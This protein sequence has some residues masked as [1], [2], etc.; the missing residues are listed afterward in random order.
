MINL[1]KSPKIGTYKVVCHTNFNHV[2]D[3]VWEEV[4][5]KF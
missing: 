5:L 1:Y 4:S 3:V 2:L